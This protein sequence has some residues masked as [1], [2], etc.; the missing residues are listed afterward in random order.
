M[1]NVFVSGQINEKEGIQRIYSALEEIGIFITHDW[2]QTDDVAKS[3]KD[4][5]EAG[6]RA[7][8]DILGVCKADIYLIITDNARCGKGMYVELGAALALAESGKDISIYVV[9]PKNHPSIFYS[10]PRCAHFNTIDLC[11]AH[12]ARQHSELNRREKALA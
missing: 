12:I 5:I 11:I 1:M 6:K 8:K 9:G 10:H 2:T 7:E 4:S 3:E